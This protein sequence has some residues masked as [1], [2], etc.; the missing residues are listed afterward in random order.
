MAA[1]ADDMLVGIIDFAHSGLP[2]VTRA[3]TSW[4]EAEIHYLQPPAVL[5]RLILSLR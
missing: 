2:H 3:S 5:T 4:E 1:T